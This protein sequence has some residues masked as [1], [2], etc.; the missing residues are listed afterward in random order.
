MRPR[1]SL[2]TALED[3][4]LLDFGDSSR[5][6]WRALLLASRGEAL[7]PEEL[8]HFRKLTGREES[9]TDP[10]RLL[11]RKY[12]AEKGNTDFNRPLVYPREA[13]R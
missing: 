11:W 3:P 9:P 4:N 10:N 8:E 7:T 1:V 12:M 6:A 5:I 13:W 2:R